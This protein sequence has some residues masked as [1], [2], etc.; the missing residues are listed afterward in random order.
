MAGYGSLHEVKKLWTIDDVA[1]AHEILDLQADAER[2][3]RAKN[4]GG[5]D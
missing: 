2:R 1:D 3:A 4:D 5:W